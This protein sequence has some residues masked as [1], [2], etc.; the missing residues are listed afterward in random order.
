MAELNTPLRFGC[1][2]PVLLLKL[3]RCGIPSLGF[4]LSSED[5]I[6]HAAMKVCYLYCFEHGRHRNPSMSIQSGAYWLLQA[7]QAVPFLRLAQQRL[8]S[9][10]NA[11]AVST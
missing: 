7:F 10:E 1:A 11:A 5:D 8:Q 9:F 6:L 3:T 2:S 4:E